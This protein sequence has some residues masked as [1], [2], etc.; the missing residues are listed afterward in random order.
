MRNPD[1]LAEALIGDPSRF[2]LDLP[3]MHALGQSY[4]EAMQDA[5]VAGTVCAMM[6]R[7][8]FIDDALESAIAAGATQLM[9]LG[10]GFDSH[11]VRF[12][13]LLEHLNVFEVDRQATQEYKRAMLAKVIGELP[14]NLSFV[15]LGDDSDDLRELLTRHGFDFARRT[16]VIMEGLTMYLSEAALRHNF[17]L[18]ASLPVGSSI[19]FDFVSS[20]MLQLITSIDLSR[21]VGAPRVFA[22]RFLHLTRDEPWLFGFPFRGEREYI[23]AFGLEVKEILNVSG[24]EAVR[25]YL[26]RD[27]GSRVSDE[28]LAPLRQA[29]GATAAAQSEAMVYRITEAFVPQRH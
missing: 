12:A 2:E 21:L 5:E 22:E 19:A 15:P 25:R 10:A 17:G 29:E 1:H 3:V 7:A 18:L 27:D 13:P 4:D 26:T 24:A 11:A 9:V 28:V 23:E 14:A 8:R 16:F 6:V 20:A